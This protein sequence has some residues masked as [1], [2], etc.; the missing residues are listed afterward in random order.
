[1]QFCSV[2]QQ[3]VT[4]SRYVHSYRSQSSSV[5]TAGPWATRR[6]VSAR[7]PAHRTAMAVTGTLGPPSLRS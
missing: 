6:A 4:P 2:G 1:M 5:D 3:S 7:V